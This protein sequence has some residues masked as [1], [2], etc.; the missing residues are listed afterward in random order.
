M[1]LM[2]DP[3]IATPKQMNNSFSV[4]G[5]VTSRLAA[6]PTATCVFPVMLNPFEIEISENVCSCRCY[7]IRFRAKKKQKTCAF[8]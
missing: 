1:S 7:H 8:R 4:E 6:V 3:T 2:T 5:C